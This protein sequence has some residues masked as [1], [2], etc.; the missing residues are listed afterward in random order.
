MAATKAVRLQV[1]HPRNITIATPASAAHAGAPQPP[2]RTAGFVETYG[3]GICRGRYARALCREWHA[4]DEQHGSEND[5]VDAFPADQLF[6]VFVVADGGADLEHFEVRS[7]AEARS[8]LLQVGADCNAAHGKQL[9]SCMLSSGSFA[10]NTFHGRCEST[11][12]A[13]FRGSDTKW[14]DT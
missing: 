8:I 4:W 11:H 12:V 9:R 7:A 3:V 6:V 2:N 1:H 13:P 14:E 10:W 5:P